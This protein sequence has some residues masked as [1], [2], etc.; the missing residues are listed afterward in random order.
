[1]CKRATVIK[2]IFTFV[3]EESIYELKGVEEELNK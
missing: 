2:K 1:M 3:V